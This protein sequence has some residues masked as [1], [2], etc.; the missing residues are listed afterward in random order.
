MTEV[1]IS[2]LPGYS[3]ATEQQPIIQN[4]AVIPAQPDPT[5]HTSKQIHAVDAVF[6]HDDEQLTAFSFYALWSGA[7]FLGD[8]AREHLKHSEEEEDEEQPEESPRRD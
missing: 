3:P 2:L 7:M 1:F 5:V 4:E 8:M 6:A